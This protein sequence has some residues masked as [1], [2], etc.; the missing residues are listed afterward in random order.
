MIE[1]ATQRTRR[2]YLRVGVR[3][4]LALQEKAPT[5]NSACTHACDRDQIWTMNKTL[6]RA[7]VCRA[8]RFRK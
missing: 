1:K 4:A 5:D 2:F 6:F 7:F 3:D 8:L